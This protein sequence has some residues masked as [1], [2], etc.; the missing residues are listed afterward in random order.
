MEPTTDPRQRFSSRVADYTAGRPGYPSAIV[1][2]MRRE[3]GM[4]G[5]SV[6]ADIGSGTGLL[7][8]LFLQAGC[9]TF[10]VEPNA[11]MRQAG[12][13]ALADESRFTSIDGSAEAT[14]L[15]DD[16]VDLIVAGQAFHWFNADAARAEFARILRPGGGVASIWNERVTSGDAFLVGYERLLLDCGADYRQVDHRRISE[17]QLRSFFAPHAL[18]YREFAN[19]QKL[20]REALFA[21]VRSCSYM[22]GPDHPRHAIMLGR[23]DDLFSAFAQNGSVVL[24]YKTRVWY[25][26]MGGPA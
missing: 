15:P 18:H 8:R 12:E 6:V 23:I 25:G 4:T 21:R 9:K 20:D 3:C 22:P 17:D 1:E 7:S 14:G 13:A 11:P 24:A 19:L 26:P 10:G 16:S 5:Q 2:L